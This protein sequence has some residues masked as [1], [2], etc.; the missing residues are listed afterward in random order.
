MSF[1][2]KRE[3]A[4]YIKFRFLI[5]ASIT[6]HYLCLFTNTTLLFSGARLFA[7]AEKALLGMCLFSRIRVRNKLMFVGSNSSLIHV[8]A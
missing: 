3:I 1:C 8:F 2:T 6:F 7:S 4:I 5:L